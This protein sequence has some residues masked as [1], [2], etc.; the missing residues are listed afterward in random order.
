[1]LDLGRQLKPVDGD[2]FY[3]NWFKFLLDSALVLLATHPDAQLIKAL[4]V[5]IEDDRLDKYL[6]EKQYTE[7][8]VMS[9]WNYLFALIWIVVDCRKETVPRDI[10]E[11]KRRVGLYWNA[12]VYGVFRRYLLNAPIQ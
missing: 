6:K 10:N 1:M 5:A 7:P 4:R 12:S 2:A 11:L 8:K 3:Y 9:A